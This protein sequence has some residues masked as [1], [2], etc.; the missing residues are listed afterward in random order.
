MT[1]QK[2]IDEINQM[3]REASEELNQERQKLFDEKWELL[4]DEI[5]RQEEQ[6]IQYEADLAWGRLVMENDNIEKE[7]YV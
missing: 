6:Q 5:A 3:F 4:K 2:S 7:M 1:D